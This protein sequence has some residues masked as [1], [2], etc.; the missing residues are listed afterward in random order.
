MSATPEAADQAI[1]FDNKRTGI[2]VDEPGALRS[3]AILTLHTRQA[4]RLVFGRRADTKTPP[5]HGLMRWAAALRQ[6]WAGAANSD[7][8]ADWYLVQIEESIESG[9]ETLSALQE[10][11]DARL[12]ALP[13][14]LQVNLAQAATPYQID[15]QFA[16]PHAYQGTYLLAAYDQLVCAILTARHIALLDRIESERLLDKGGKVIRRLFGLGLKYRYTG[17]TRDELKQ[18]TQRAKRAIETMGELP[19]I[20]LDGELNPVFRPER[21]SAAEQDQQVRVEQDLQPGMDLRQRLL[22]KTVD[23]DLSGNVD[24]SQKSDG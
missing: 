2:P 14:G 9:S 18:N 10:Q 23:V 6:V 3:N 22:S 21:K 12:K 13:T 16:S 24:V 15:L 19:Q 5:I 7:P 4:Q 1:R 17:V 11:M 20:I 8:Y